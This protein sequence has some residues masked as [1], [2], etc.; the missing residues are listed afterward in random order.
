MLHIPGKG[1]DIVLGGT[2][3]QGRSPR[4]TVTWGGVRLHPPGNLSFQS[5]VMWDRGD[6]SLFRS[7]F[8][9]AGVMVLA[10]WTW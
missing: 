2:H 8:L 5:F 6:G 4:L 9:L 3:V 1:V 10:G 7:Y